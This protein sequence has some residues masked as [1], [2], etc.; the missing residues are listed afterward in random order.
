LSISFAC[1]EIENRETSQAVEQV[2]RECIGHRPA[3]D[4][5]VWIEAGPNYCRVEVKGPGPARMTYFFQDSKALPKKVRDWLE[6][7]PLR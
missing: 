6:L 3:E 2:I 4:W 1:N 5:N 7:Y